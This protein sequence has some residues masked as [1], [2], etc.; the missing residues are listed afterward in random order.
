MA[1]PDLIAAA[2]DLWDYLAARAWG[3]YRSHGRG[4][5]MLEADQLQTA[6]QQQAAGEPITVEPDFLPLHYVP[7]GD[8]FRPLILQYDPE[9]QALLLIRLSD[10]SDQLIALEPHDRLAPEACFDHWRTTS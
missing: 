1:T 8:D 10:N 9:R 4:V 5:L 2:T 6:R 3:N 7:S